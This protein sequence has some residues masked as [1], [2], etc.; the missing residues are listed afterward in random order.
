QTIA[1]QNLRSPRRRVRDRQA[2]NKSLQVVF[3]RQK[4]Q[5][6]RRNLLYRPVEPG[7]VLPDRIVNRRRRVCSSLGLNQKLVN[8]KL[9]RSLFGIGDGSSKV[10]DRFGVLS[11]RHRNLSESDSSPGH[12]RT[13]QR[14]GL[15]RGVCFGGGFVK[16]FLSGK[17]SCEPRVHSR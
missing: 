5:L 8:G 1:S 6:V 11:L 14:L 9:R 10:L 15:E 17:R 3:Y 4:K 12:R 16:L 7:H 13:Y 2:L